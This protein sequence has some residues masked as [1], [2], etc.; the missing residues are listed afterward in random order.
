MICKIQ[1]DNYFYL[2]E[3]EESKIWEQDGTLKY[4]SMDV[5]N[6]TWYF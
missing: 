2:K 5:S 4:L 1:W 3:H 6:D